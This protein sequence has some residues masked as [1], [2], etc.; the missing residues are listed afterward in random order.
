MWLRSVLCEVVAV[1]AVVVAGA[2][3]LLLLQLLGLARYAILEGVLPVYVQQVEY[4][5]SCVLLPV[6]FL[7]ASLSPALGTALDM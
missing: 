7:P 1:A 6:V 2:A 4:L 3:L 5:A